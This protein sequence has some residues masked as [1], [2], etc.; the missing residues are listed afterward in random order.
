MFN[1]VTIKTTT[2]T[3]CQHQNVL[4]SQ[5]SNGSEQ[6]ST[7]FQEKAEVTGSAQGS[8]KI[9]VIIRILQKPDVHK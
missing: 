6:F 3:R 5:N 1:S 7:A 4:Q 2:T 8:Y 9:V